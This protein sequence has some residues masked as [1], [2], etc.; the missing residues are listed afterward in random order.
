MNGTSQ[1]LVSVRYYGLERL[2]KIISL[3]PP[4]VRLH[5]FLVRKV[6]LLL[7]TTFQDYYHFKPCLNILNIVKIDFM[8]KIYS[9]CL[10]FNDKNLKP[11]LDS[12]YTTRASNNLAFCP[13]IF[14]IL[15][16]LGTISSVKLQL[17]WPHGTT[18]AR[19]LR[20]TGFTITQLDTH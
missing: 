2:P 13:H 14:S 6:L 4:L 8:S 18:C 9:L 5:S 3:N 17:Q 1:T 20:Y 12:L 15:Y 19:K 7:V 10:Y 11:H 16:S